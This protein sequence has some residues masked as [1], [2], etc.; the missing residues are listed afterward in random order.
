M[1]SVLSLEANRNGCECDD[2][3]DDDGAGRSRKTIRP[4]Y[5]KHFGM[6]ATA[7]MLR[8]SN[9]LSSAVAAYAES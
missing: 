1:I 5:L 7:Q 8:A 2:D 4:G 6:A 9:Q 3:D